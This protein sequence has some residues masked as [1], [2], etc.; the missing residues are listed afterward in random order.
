MLARRANALTTD[1]LARLR[2][3]ASAAPDKAANAVRQALGLREAIYALADA[4]LAQR[5][6]AQRDLR[7]LNRYR[8]AAA[9]R[10]ELVPGTGSLVRKWSVASAL[11]APLWPVAESACAL[12][13]DEQ[14]L[15]RLRA[16]EGD[17]CGWLFID[18]S[19]S[20][21]RRW[22]DMTVCGNRA[23]AARHYASKTSDPDES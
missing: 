23:K 4:W 13:T 19:R 9:S 21:R 17:G 10:S 20:G 8:R 6:P 11:V 12:L 2:A 7:V 22:C 16:C 5:D 1:E 18:Q 3:G 14:R 15:A